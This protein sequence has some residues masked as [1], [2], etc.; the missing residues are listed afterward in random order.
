MS[1]SVSRPVVEVNHSVFEEGWFPPPFPSSSPG[2][3]APL[4]SEWTAHVRPSEEQC[5]GLG[6]F[7]WRCCSLVLGTHLQ[8]LWLPLFSLLVCVLDKWCCHLGYAL[9]KINPSSQSLW[10]VAVTFHC[11]STL[12]P[13]MF[14]SRGSCLYNKGRQPTPGTM[15]Q[16]TG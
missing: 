13:F 4:F 2:G 15:N 16:A 8:C 9:W 12:T 5:V 10:C 11:L 7:C 1:L 14:S 3:Q 6:R